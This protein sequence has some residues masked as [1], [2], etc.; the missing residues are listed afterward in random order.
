MELEVL[1]SEK[2][3]RV[4]TVGDRLMYMVST[5]TSS[6]SLVDK[7]L[8]KGGEVGYKSGGGQD[9]AGLSKEPSSLK[10]SIPFSVTEGG[11]TTERRGDSFAAAQWINGEFCAEES[12]QKRDE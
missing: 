4:K 1:P 11:I 8:C 3:F 12:L 10:T 7:H 6:Q 9:K 5:F 2:Q